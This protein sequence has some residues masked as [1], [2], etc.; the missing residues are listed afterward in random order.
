MI[1]ATTLKSKALAPTLPNCTACGERLLWLDL[2]P[3]RDSGMVLEQCPR[4]GVKEAPPEHCPPVS[5]P[6]G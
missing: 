2:S 3:R 1:D 4:C 5:H 6:N